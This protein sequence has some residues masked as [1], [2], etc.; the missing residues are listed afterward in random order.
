MN[1]NIGN[2]YLGDVRHRFVEFKALAEAAVAQVSDD[3]WFKT[4][5]SES[6]SIA[7]LLKHL[8]GNMHA[9]GAGFPQG[10]ET[11]TAARNRDAEFEVGGADTKSALMAQWEAGWQCAFDA[12]DSLSA[13]DLNRRVILRGES[14]LVLAAINRQFAHYAYHVGQIVFLAKHWQSV[15]WNSLSIPRGKSAQFEAD[16]RR[17]PG[18]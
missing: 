5:D 6:N 7:V 16:V 17:K 9:R 1:A 15:E 4:P 8:A 13:D 14:L 3:D 11:E 18:T 2:V 10:G 12:L